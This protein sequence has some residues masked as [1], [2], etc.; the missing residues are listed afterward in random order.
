MPPSGLGRLLE[1][2][3]PGARQLVRFAIAGG[4]AYAKVFNAET[5]VELLMLQG[6]E[7]SKGHEDSIVTVRFDPTD[8]RFFFV[9]RAMVVPSAVVR[10][11]ARP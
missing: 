6:Q 4:P 7:D 10:T 1:R 2:L 8:L 11:A 5:G 3:P 9:V